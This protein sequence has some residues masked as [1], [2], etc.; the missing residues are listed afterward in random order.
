VTR[1]PTAEFATVQNGRHDVLNDAAHRAV[2][3][4]IVQRLER[5]RSGATILTVEGP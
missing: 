4:H 1:L 3:A 5:P 2:A